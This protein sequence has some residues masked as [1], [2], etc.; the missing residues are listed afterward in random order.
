MEKQDDVFH[1]RAV[2]AYETEEFSIDPRSGFTRKLVQMKHMI[3]RPQTLSGLQPELVY[4]DCDLYGLNLNFINH[5]NQAGTTAFVA[6]IFS[7][8]AGEAAAQTMIRF[9][10]SLCNGESPSQA[11]CLARKTLYDATAL[12]G[13]D[14][15]TAVRR[16]FPFRV[17]RLI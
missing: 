13:G 11:L 17:Y 16:A 10:R 15:V 1:I 4:F 6:T 9:F 12:E 8:Q 3:V 5:F 14:N 7:R 2:G